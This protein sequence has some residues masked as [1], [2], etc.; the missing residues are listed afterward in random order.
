MTTIAASSS[1]K[2]DMSLMSQDTNTVCSAV[3]V[4]TWQN[5]IMA[6]DDELYSEL[7][8]PRSFKVP[9]SEKFVTIL[10]I[11]SS[12]ILKCYNDDVTIT[13]SGLVTQ[14]Q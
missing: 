2:T 8:K 14:A 9:I 7:L 4:L 12:W 3:I 11:T 13:S 10:Q 6:W 5:F 1:V